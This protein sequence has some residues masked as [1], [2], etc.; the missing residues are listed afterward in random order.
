MEELAAAFQAAMSFV[1][2]QSFTASINAVLPIVVFYFYSRM[3]HQ[4]D[5][6][7]AFTTIT[8]LGLL[9][10]PISAIPMMVNQLVMMQVN[11]KRIFNYLVA[12]E[13]SEYV[14]KSHSA[15]T[16]DTMTIE[17][18]DASLGWTLAEEGSP[19][20]VCAPEGKKGVMGTRNDETEVA[21]QRNA[22]VQVVAIPNSD[23]SKGL[24]GEYEKISNDSAEMDVAQS[25]AVL[26]D[27]NDEG[28]ADFGDSVKGNSSEVVQKDS[29]LDRAVNTLQKI[30]FS[31]KQGQLVALVGKVGSGKSSLL[32]ALLNELNLLNGS[33]SLVG[34]IAYH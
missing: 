33:V 6:V 34:S 25:A 4:L 20:S 12:D 29:L 7:K 32:A 14:Q 5:F 10:G 3:G 23:N 13:I 1:F 27:G 28:S 11:A 9:Q 16:D 22:E 15:L 26:I 19:L 31:V 8:Y 24:A 18:C 17:F 2:S 21:V 30:S